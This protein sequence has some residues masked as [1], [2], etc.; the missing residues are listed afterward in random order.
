M[1]PLLLAAL[2]FVVFAATVARA[3]VADDICAPAA[4]PCVVNAAV[5]VAPGSIIDVGARGFQL[6]AQGRLTVSGVVT[7]QAGGIRLLPGARVLG[8]G[9]D[10]GATLTLRSAGALSLEVAGSARS[11][12]DVSAALAAGTVILE[13]G[14]NV[15]LDGDVAANG[16]SQ[17][18]SGGGISVTAGGAITV[19]GFLEVKGGGAADG[20]FIA[21][22]AGD[23]IDVAQVLN[24]SGGDFGGGGLELTAGGDIVTHDKLD[25]RG[26]GISGDGGSVFIDAAGSVSVLGAVSGPAAGDADEGGGTGADLDITAQQAITLAGTITITGALPDGE[27]GSVAL[28]AGTNVT[29][30]APIIA[31]GNGV[32]GCGGA[33]D[34][35]AGRDVRLDR[36]DVSGGSC[37]GGTVWAQGLGTVTAAGLVSADGSTDFGTGGF[38]T[39]QGRDVV[40]TAVVRANGSATSA[41]GTISVE[42]C[43]ITIGAASELRTLG[44]QGLNDLH[45][46]GRITVNGRMTASTGGINAIRYRDPML[47]PILSGVVVPLAAPVVDPTIP[48]CPPAGAVCGNGTTEGGEE[49]DDGNNVAC[50]GC[51]ASCRAEACGNARIEC[52]E[53]CDLGAQNGAAGSA[54]RGDCTVVPPTGGVLR[55]PGGTGRNACYAEWTLRNPAGEV[56]DGMPARTQRCVDGDPACDQ[57]GA[58]DGKCV[59]ELGVCLGADDPRVPTCQPDPIESVSLNAPNPL[60]VSAPTDVA[61]ATAL[62]QALS[63]LGVTVRA[64]TNVLV[65]GQAI[66]QR[67]ACTAPVAFVVPHPAG[68]PAGKQLL[69]AART[70]DGGRMRRNRIDVVCD[71]NVAVCGNGVRELG[72]QCDDGNTA[73]CDGCTASCRAETCGDGVVQCNEQCDDGPANGT[74]A[75][76]CEAWCAEKV[77][78]LRIPG[79]GSRAADCQLETA[80]ALA[81]PAVDGKG[82]PSSKQTCVDGDPG[83]DRDPTPGRCAFATWACVAGDDAR[84]GCTATH[85]NSLEIRRPTTRDTGALASVRAALQGGL[86]AYLPTGPGEV[87]SGRMMLGVPV[88][89]AWTKVQLRTRN[90]ANVADTDTLKLRCLAPR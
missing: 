35:V 3:T 83:C 30:T 53:E 66:A 28:E 65:A 26:G 82:M 14:T 54:C 67:D 80:I 32:D 24:A 48:A 77:P 50:D 8:Q 56:V 39:L 58:S 75:S 61:N 45:G 11:R 76:S 7:V 36:I 20:G 38:I 64:G 40:T 27:G 1:R 13:A 17:D 22:V 43:A 5:T 51:A 4:D 10:F 46:G 52:D 29:Q 62:V 72:E 70:V 15:D 16:T 71:P 25:V 34:M 37:G 87:C 2:P 9:G 19:D 84:L 49:C 68:L 31:T 86:G 12:I 44:L 42:A 59:L 89:K 60:L 33:I 78:A 85:V 63:A 21:L 88:G 41:G 79:G 57:D 47:P 23:G 18:G 73:S 69:M 55:I 74:P 6:G 81:S 90:D